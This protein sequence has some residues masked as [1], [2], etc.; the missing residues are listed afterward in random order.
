VKRDLLK[1]ILDSI[2]TSQYL[3]IVALVITVWTHTLCSVIDEITLLSLDALL[4]FLDFSLV[5]LTT[6]QLSLQLLS[7]YLLKVIVL[8]QWTV[9]L[10]PSLSYSHQVHK[11]DSI[12]ALSVSLLIAHLFLHDY[13][14]CT[15]KQRVCM[16]ILNFLPSSRKSSTP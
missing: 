5:L 7:H 6:N 8:H 2:S 12:W 14:G 3:Y 16:R 10:S 13:S 9:H 11:L 1:A 15:I 4:L